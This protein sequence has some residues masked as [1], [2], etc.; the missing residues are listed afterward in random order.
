[1]NL[2]LNMNLSVLL[3]T[4]FLCSYADDKIKNKTL[5]LNH[6]MIHENDR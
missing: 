5:L 6:D 2:N 4:H 3:N 1:M